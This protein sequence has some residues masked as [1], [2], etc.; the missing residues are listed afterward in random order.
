MRP[1]F[2]GGEP[3]FD[4]RKA[5]LGKPFSAK[6]GRGSG[7]KLSE[8]AYFG[9]NPGALRMFGYS[10]EGLPVGSP[11][12]VVLHG[13]GQSA[14]DYAHAAGWVTL[15][16]RLDFA[17]LAPEQ[18]RANNPNG[19]F[20][21]F[22]P[23][24]TRRGRGEAAS[25]HQMIQ[26]AL[27]D[28]GLDPC[29][30]FITGLSAGGAMASVMLATYPDTFAGGAILAGLPYRAAENVQDALASM[31]QPPA[32]TPRAWGDLVRGASI[33][34]GPWPTVAVW[35]GSA[36]TTV[37]PANA[38]I[39]IEQW[40]N[41][42]GIS[43]TSAIHENVD[44]YPRRLW[45]D[46][47]GRSVVESYTIVGMPHGS[48]ISSGGEQHQCGSARPFVLEAGISSSYRIAE[49]WGL[50]P[51][52]RAAAQAASVVDAPSKESATVYRLGDV[53][54]QSR[55]EQFGSSRIQNVISKALKAAG[56]LK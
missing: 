16:E 12:V 33:H 35:H 45:R 40:L 37:N 11:L 38:E 3:S 34:R 14:D 27:T 25:I 44:G 6:P 42:H 46:A 52:A 50:A 54:R 19:C 51:T 9:S 32:Y 56:L 26:C 15:A 28:Y 55:Q 49:F 53:P 2:F 22:E 31:R 39:I 43:Q 18:N 20:N 1:I 29:R 21:W 47:D 30:I 17:L 24:D 13:C 36:D 5:N 41:V 23:D 8:T 7:G 4:W 10:P 48:P